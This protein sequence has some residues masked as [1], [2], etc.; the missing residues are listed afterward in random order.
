MNSEL[1]SWV[2]TL[3]FTAGT[4]ASVLNSASVAQQATT[5][6]GKELAATRIRRFPLERFRDK[7][8][9]DIPAHTY[10]EWRWYKPNPLSIAEQKNETIGIR[11]AYHG[12]WYNGAG[13]QFRDGSF[14][15]AN[16]FG[17]WGHDPKTDQLHFQF[18]W[19]FHEM[20]AYDPGNDC[21][22]GFHTNPSGE[23]CLINFSLNEQRRPEKIKVSAIEFGRYLYTDSDRNAWFDKDA[24]IVRRD[25]KLLANRGYGNPVTRIS[26]HLAQQNSK[27]LYRMSR[28]GLQMFEAGEWRNASG[29]PRLIGPVRSVSQRDD[30]VAIA[31][32]NGAI[33]WF[34]TLGLSFKLTDKFTDWIAIDGDGRVWMSDLLCLDDTTQ[35][36]P[37]AEEFA[38]TLRRVSSKEP[39]IATRA[40][41][42][43]L[44]AGKNYRDWIQENLTNDDLEVRT[45]AETL[46]DCM[47]G[48]NRLQFSGDQLLVK[49]LLGG[50]GT[51]PQL[52]P[53]PE[54]NKDHRATYDEKDALILDTRAAG[55]LKK[56]LLVE[57]PVLGHVGFRFAGTDRA[58]VSANTV[59]PE[60]YKITHSAAK[61]DLTPITTESPIHYASAGRNPD[62]L[63]AILG[64]LKGGRHQRLE[65]YRLLIGTL[66]TDSGDFTKL[67]ELRSRSLF[68][69]HLVLQR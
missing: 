63:I 29:P 8:G 69:G 32:N 27:Q 65:D 52:L 62:E 5:T 33:E 9:E 2:T 26:W 23:H 38:V 55:N 67:G 34:P 58:L 43:L 47:N 7:T 60:Y 17:V 35:P 49:E 44:K 46:D 16:S 57:T 14:S 28:F 45:A 53:I 41:R 51:A 66:K 19:P 6:E 61:L 37:T 24:W 31:T 59:T 4:L 42:R 39:I 64:S 68:S 54:Q 1:M 18:A 50:A 13:F 12:G 22:W 11:T 48:R 30:V 10:G 36:A 56:Y 40:M 25:D 20:C 21:F 3:L 15:I